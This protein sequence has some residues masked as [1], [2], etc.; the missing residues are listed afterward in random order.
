MGFI[1]FK[2]SI[3]PFQSMKLPWNKVKEEKKRLEQELDE[4]EQQK[5]KLEERFEAEQKRRKKLSREKQEA[6]EERNKLRNKVSSLKA[7]MGGEKSTD[8]GGGNSREM[9]FEDAKKLLRKL[10]TVSSEK[11][12][13]ATV[14]A[15]QKLSDIR[16]TKGLKNSIPKRQY[17][18]IEDEKGFV[19][20]LDQQLGG[21]VLG[22]TPFFQDDFTV[23]DSFQVKDIQEFTTRE[24]YW[25]LASSGYTEIYRE[26]NGDFEQLEVVKS[27]VNREHSKG[28]FSQGRFEKKREEQVEGHFKDVKEHIEKLNLDEDC[29]YV[30][31]DKKLS[32]KLPGTYLGG[33]DPNRELPERFY[34]LRLKRF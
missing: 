34:K 2:P 23:S 13:M 29:L 1:R 25:V 21:F 32:K 28:G 11:D 24:K 27:R 3:I 14:Y 16:D 30:L 22:I 17:K 7:Q 15:P 12:D 5:I 9:S 4:L 33:F 10:S 18:E 26:E 19:A 20:F 6:Q 8:D 31:G